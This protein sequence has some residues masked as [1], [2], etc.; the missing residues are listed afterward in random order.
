MDP[1]GCRLHSTVWVVASSSA[2]F[3]TS[4]ARCSGPLRHYAILRKDAPSI[5]S[6]L[7]RHSCQPACT[8]NITQVG[9]RYRKLAAIGLLLGFQEQPI[10]RCTFRDGHIP[11]SRPPP[12]DRPHS[13]D[14]KILSRPFF[15]AHEPDTWSL[16]ERRGLGGIA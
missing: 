8:R 3:S 4:C 12:P 14:C 11:D 1:P 6:V 13:T 2:S 5:A 10:A 7:A 9:N 16:D 15:R